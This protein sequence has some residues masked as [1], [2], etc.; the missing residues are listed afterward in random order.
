MN[1]IFPSFTH[2]HTPAHQ[3]THIHSIDMMEIVNFIH[4]LDNSFLEF[5]STSG[6]VGD[7][8]EYSALF[9][10]VSSGVNGRCL[11]SSRLM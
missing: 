8:Q 10:E 9:V 3:H 5:S 11:L 4:F 2:T 6:D 1:L 7:T